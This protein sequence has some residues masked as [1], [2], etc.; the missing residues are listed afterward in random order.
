MWKEAESFN[1]CATSLKHKASRSQVIKEI[2]DAVLIES[3]G[4]SSKKISCKSFNFSLNICVGVDADPYVL[5]HESIKLSLAR[6]DIDNCF[7][8][9]IEFYVLRFF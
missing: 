4:G 2:H 3:G 5:F 9:M 1:V 8:L 7:L 6:G